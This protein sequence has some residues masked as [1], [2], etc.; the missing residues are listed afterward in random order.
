LLFR[1]TIFLFSL[2]SLAGC[3]FTPI[4]SPRTGVL[5]EEQIQRI[6]IEPIEGRA[7]Q[8]LLIFLEQALTPDGQVGS[9][10]YILNVSL[11]ISEQ[12]LAIKKSAIATRANITYIGRY[13]LIE[14]ATGKQL[15]AGNSRVVASYNVLSQAYATMVSKKDTQKRLA[16]EMALDIGNKVRVYFKFRRKPVEK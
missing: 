11:S 12:S 9:V 6:K 15:T 16:R 8:H 2:V 3:G 14:K 13:G 1:N 5:L 4:Y 10:K 7:G